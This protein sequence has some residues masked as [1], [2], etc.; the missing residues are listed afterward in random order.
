MSFHDRVG[1]GDHRDVARPDLDGGR[2]HALSE[3]ALGVGRDRLVLLRDEVPG[4]QRL[5]GRSAHLLAERV[6]GQRLLDDVHD[7]GLHRIDVG[8]EVADE[9]GLGQPGERLALLEPE[10]RDVD[11]ADRVRRVGA[12]RGHDLTAVGVPLLNGWG[13]AT[14]Y[15]GATAGLSRNPV[16]ERRS[17]AASS[18]WAARWSR[19]LP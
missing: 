17:P 1:L 5:P 11:E 10:A 14:T 13:R 2:A 6:G 19:P 12:E 9:V 7:P 16:N 8:G 15:R 18:P 3:L 4:G